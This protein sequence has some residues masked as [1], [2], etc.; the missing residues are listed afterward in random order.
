MKKKNTAL[1]AGIIILALLL[2]FYLVLHN[3]SKEDSQDTEKTSETAFETTVEDISEAVFKSG[4]NE[5]KF[6]KSDDIWKYNGEENFPLDQSAFEEIIS[7]FEKIAADR[8]LEK[9]DNI[10]EYGLDDPTVTVSL[11]DKDGKEQ[12]LQFG[13]TNSV[14]S[15]SYMT[16][17]K[18]NEKVY[19]VSSTIVTSLQFD[20]NDLAEKE[21]FPSITDIT[22]VIM[23]RNGQ[24]FSVFKDSSSSTGWTVTGWDGTKKDAG[25]SQ[26][27]EFTNPI[28]S[29][30]WSSFISQNT[31]DL[32][33]YGLD[34]P[35]IIT[36][37]Y[38]VTETKSTDETK[39]DSADTANGSNTTDNK[40]KDA[41]AESDTTE[42]TEEKV[43][44]DKQEVLLIGNKTEDNSYYAK[45][46]S[47][48]GVYT[49][50][51]STVDNLL[52]AEVNQ[53]LSTYVSD[54]IFADLDKVTIEKDGN[55][56]E[57]T[58]KTEEKQVESDSDKENTEDTDTE[59][60]ETTTVTTYYMNGKEIELSDFSEFYSLISGMECQERLDTVPDMENSP[61]M[62][63][64]FYKENGVDVTT[65]YYAYDSSFYLVKDSKGNASL[66]NKM[67][68]KELTEAFNAFLEKQN[69]ES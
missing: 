13:D 11:K 30:S 49:L 3:S 7:K 20:I 56:Y 36:I 6:T 62:T 58:K 19:M 29:L 63:V 52:N 54:Y 14:T 8:V 31:E 24:T 21:T 17:N 59:E 4:E 22:G 43:T 35:T 64:H 38:Q 67:K 51:S 45:L 46:Q 50:S 41:K 9:P 1:I 61:E 69:K 60:E 5:F 44:V 40:S 48:S 26:V 34:N 39:D 28:T 10:S 57:F 12:T 42:D 32:S 37:N 25:S 65:E 16:L 18:D 66:V 68:V 55:T 27:S 23:E 2:V 53:F 33:Q 15:S 47:Q